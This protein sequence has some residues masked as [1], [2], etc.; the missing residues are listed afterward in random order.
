MLQSMV[1]YAAENPEKQV[2][3]VV[4]S[5]SQSLFQ[6]ML[7]IESDS[8]FDSILGA[9]PIDQ[10]VDL[11]E[12]THYLLVEDGGIV[13]MFVQDETGMVYDVQRKE[14]MQLSWPTINQLATYFNVLEQKHFGQ[15]IDWEEANK[16]VPR[17][18]TF[19]ITDIETGLSFNAQ[20]RAG[21]D[22]ADVQP[23]TKADTKIIKQ[24]YDGKW[25]WKR[26]AILIHINHQVIAGSMH[27]MPHGRGAL[28]NG[29][30]GHFCVHFKGSTTHTKKKSDLSHQAMIY[31]AGG[32]LNQFVKQLPVEDVIA[33][34]FIAL[35]QQDLELLD[36]LYNGEVENYRRLIKQIDVAR[37]LQQDEPTIDHTLVYEVLVKYVVK[38]KGRHEKE[39]S[40]VFRL[41]RD[42]PTG[43]WKID[44]MPFEQDELSK[45]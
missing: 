25:S 7:A 43:G 44:K 39:K 11:P 19:R 24:I 31:K 36:L 14:R 13:R 4:K 42:S 9:K 34:F 26:R 8:L 6:T 32:M 37:I 10:T 30:P 3:I 41:L 5:S 35:D 38:E 2:L 33:L 20:R 12:S 40:F 15:V 28:A 23:L 45:N 1:T 29:F 27:G 16:A 21:S 22:H 17:Y 18:A